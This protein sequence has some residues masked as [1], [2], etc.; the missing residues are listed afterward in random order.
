M[1]FWTS[2]P[3]GETAYH[4]APKATTFSPF[5]W[6]FLV[7]FT[8]VYS[9]WWLYVTCRRP[10]ARFVVPSRD[11]FAPVPACGFAAAISGGQKVA[12]FPVQELLPFLSLS[13]R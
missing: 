11:A 9:G 2:A 1:L 6:P 12:H 8:N 7:S 5:V 13:N 3:A 10:S 4:S